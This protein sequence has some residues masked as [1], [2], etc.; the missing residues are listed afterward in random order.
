MSTTTDVVAVEPLEQPADAELAPLAQALHAAHLLRAEAQPVAGGHHVQ[1]G[2]SVAHRDLVEP[3]PVQQHVGQPDCRGSPREEPQRGIARGVGVD[4]Q[5]PTVELHQ[6]RREVDRRRALADAP[7]RIGHRD[8]SHEHPPSPPR[9]PRP[10]PAPNRGATTCYRT[11]PGP[12]LSRFLAAKVPRSP[13]TS[14]PSQLDPK[15][16]WSLGSIGTSSPMSHGLLGFPARWHRGTDD[17]RNQVTPSPS[18]ACDHGTRIP[19]DL[20]F[21]GPGYPLQPRYIA[22]WVARFHGHRVA[23][24]PWCLEAHVS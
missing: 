23:L 12:S 18:P 13:S 2:Y 20:R 6:R 3:Q 16:R 11:D 10:L 8:A 14:V 15:I 9:G 22:R 4:Q 24:V 7:L 5:H 17:A 21:T 19:R 1:P